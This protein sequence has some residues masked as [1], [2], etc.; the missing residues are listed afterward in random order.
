MSTDKKRKNFATKKK[1]SAADMEALASSAPAHNVLVDSCHDYYGPEEKVEFS[2]MSVEDFP[3]LPCTPLKEKEYK[4]VRGNLL[5]T[6]PKMAVL[7][8][9]IIALESRITELERYSRRWNL[10][11]H[12]VPENVNEKNERK[13]VVR[14]CQK[15]LPE[16]AD[17]LP[18]VIDTVH[19]VGVKKINSSRGIIIQFSSR[20]HRAAVWAAAK[21]SV[22]LRE[23]GLRFRED[24]CKA[25]RESRMKLWPLVDEARKAGKI[26]YFVADEEIDEEAFLLLDEDT[27]KNLVPKVGPRLKFL[28]LFREFLGHDQ[29]PQVEELRQEFSDAAEP[30]KG[31]ETDYKQIKYFTNSGNFIQPVEEVLPSVSFVQQRDSVTGSV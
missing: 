29:S 5:Q 31:L 10:K 26:A 20:L 14:I 16:H 21:N 4:R 12:G 2:V 17:H 30:F 11:L 13:E 23:N 3:S 15:L 8:H 9:R 6:S 19:R 25:D 24:L 18:D 27:I 22:Y 7:S 28:R 1:E